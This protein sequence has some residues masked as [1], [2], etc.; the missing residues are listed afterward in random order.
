VERLKKYLE[1]ILGKYKFG[2]KPQTSTMDQ[3]FVVRQY[4]KTLCL[5]YWPPFPLH[6]FTKAFN[7][8]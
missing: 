2:F 6:W 7:S 1:E 4:L 8:I 3:M 5:W